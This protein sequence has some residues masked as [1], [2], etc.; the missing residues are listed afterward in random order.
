MLYPFWV[1]AIAVTTISE[2]NS[3]GIQRLFQLAEISNSQLIVIGDMKTPDWKLNELPKFVHYFSI[4]EQAKKWP[5]LSGLLPLNHYARKNLAYLWALENDVDVLLDTDDD[6]YSEVDIFEN[7]PYSYRLYKGSRQWVNAYAHFGRPEIWP[8]GLPL[9]EAFKPLETTEK[10]ESSPEWH[11][12]Q[13]IVDGDPDLDAIGRM[14]NPQQHNFVE[15]DPL[16][17]GN[18]NFCPTNSQATLWNKRLFP[19]LYLPITSTFR[20]T[21]IWRG[22]IVYGYQRKFGIQT[23]FGKLGFRQERNE[24]VLA[25][26]FIDEIP[27]HVHNRKIKEISDTFWGASSGKI[28]DFEIFRSIYRQLVS[29]GILSKMEIACVNQFMDNVNAINE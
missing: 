16:V 15:L 14:L 28:S 24:H 10:I 26:D 9:E 8:R 17:L 6:N 25:A 21:D 7:I 3:L 20:M 11:C 22:I 23:V 1:R 4:H 12:F 27:G 18:N 5:K 19:F 13:S 29:V 2:Q